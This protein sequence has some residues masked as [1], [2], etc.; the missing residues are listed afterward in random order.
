MCEML[1]IKIAFDAA[2]V[3]WVTIEMA[4]R[5]NTQSWY[6]LP[7]A[8]HTFLEEYN[9]SG[10]TIVLFLAHGTDGLAGTIEDITADL[11][12]EVTIMEPI[13][14]YWPDV[15]GAHGAIQEW[16]AGLEIVTQF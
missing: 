2:I 13:G 7:M 1:K 12:D 3:V 6:T 4:D 15:D 5:Y 10:K 14:V 16:L 9:F 11:P 8:V